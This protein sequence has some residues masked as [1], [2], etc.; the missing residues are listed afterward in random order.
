M[1]A[2]LKDDHR[3]SCRM[4]A[5]LK[6]QKPCMICAACVDSR[7]MGIAR[8]SR[9]RLNHPPYSPDLSPPDYFAFP[10]VENGVEG[11]A[12]MQP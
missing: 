2:V 8:C 5:D 10:Q 7:T 4:I 1:A 9:K 3:A 11:G 6:K 12:D